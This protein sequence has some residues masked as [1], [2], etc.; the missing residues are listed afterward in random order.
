MSQSAYLSD[1][2]VAKQLLSDLPVDWPG[3][4]TVLHLKSVDYNWRQMEWWAFYF[5]WLCRDRLSREFQTPGERIDRTTFDAYRT[6]NWDFK[7][8]AVKSDDFRMI[9]NDQK[10][11]DESIASHEYHGVIVGLCDV[12][13]NDV[14]RSF[15]R[16]HEALKGGPSAYVLGRRKRTSTS[17]YRKTHAVLLE[18]QFIVFN[19]RK[20]MG[21]GIHH[22]GRNSNGRPR[23]PK[24]M[25]QIDS[26]PGVVVDRLVY[27][28]GG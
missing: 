24:Y 14:D 9:L 12:E 17:R 13:Y 18:I 4:E 21:L 1:V 23:P 19:Q 8:K 26:I 6:I 27:D 11:M 20:A 28:K 15:Q 22:Q 5:E 7:A 2:Q 25:Y 10:A 16:W 3:K